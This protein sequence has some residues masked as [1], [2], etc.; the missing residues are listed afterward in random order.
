MAEV[1]ARS[2]EGGPLRVGDA[3]LGGRK[4]MPRLVEAG[5]PTETGGSLDDPDDQAHA[6]HQLPVDIQCMHSGSR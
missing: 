5:L 3:L 4:I 2:G 6:S 1:A